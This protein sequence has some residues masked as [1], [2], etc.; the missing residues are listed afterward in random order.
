M[1]I[2]SIHCC[3]KYFHLKVHYY[4]KKYFHL[5]LTNCQPQITYLMV[6][7][8]TYCILGTSIKKYQLVISFTLS[9]SIFNIKS[10]QMEKL[11]DKIS[12]I[13][14]DSNEISSNFKISV[15]L[16]IV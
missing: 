13:D 10:W 9:Q 5:K 12:L 6:N 11:I 14:G 8:V 3:K 4:L 7:Q 15:V 16:H 1:K 2:I